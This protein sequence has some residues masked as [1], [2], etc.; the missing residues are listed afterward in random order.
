MDVNYVLYSI[1][2]YTF[3]CPS[4]VTDVTALMFMRSLS[5]IFVGGGG[6]DTESFTLPHERKFQG[7]R[8]GDW[9]SWRGGRGRFIRIDESFDSSDPRTSKFVCQYVV[10][11]D[12]TITLFLH[13]KLFIQKKKTLYE[14]F[15]VFYTAIIITFNVCT[16]NMSEKML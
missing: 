6:V 8:S 15:S 10:M 12:K 1:S 4:P 9:G 11:F 14:M 7:F 16:K 3:A 2:T 13:L 5:G